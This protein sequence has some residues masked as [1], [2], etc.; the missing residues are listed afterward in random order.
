MSLTSHHSVF[1]QPPWTSHINVALA[2]VFLDELQTFSSKPPLGQTQML[3]QINQAT[4]NA[5]INEY[6]QMQVRCGGE[7]HH[8]CP[9][10]ALTSSLQQK[11]DVGSLF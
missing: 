7:M 2:K 1:Y 3:M 6:K 8:G 11:A 4:S 9:Q 5:L 10:R